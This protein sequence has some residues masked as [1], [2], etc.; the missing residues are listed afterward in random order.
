ME[1]YPQPVSM[2]C[3]WKIWEQMRNSFCRINEY[4]IGFFCHIN[5]FNE[6]IPVIIIN[7]YIIDKDYNGTIEVIMNNKPKKIELGNVR[8]K[9]KEYN[10]SIL[11]IKE[12]KNEKY[13]YN[14]YI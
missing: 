10:I 13:N 12:N 3:I 7:N 2:K 1:E 8:Y 14:K 4:D 5:Y 6:K 9:N 11:E